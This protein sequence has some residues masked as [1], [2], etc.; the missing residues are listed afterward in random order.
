MMKCIK[1]N[2]TSIRVTKKSHEAIR[3][4][5][6]FYECG[7]QET[8]IRQGLIALIDRSIV[9]LAQT[10]ESDKIEKLCELRTKLIPKIL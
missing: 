3:E 2:D 10:E 7:N 8:V 1:L 6:E 4:L 5:K 9:R